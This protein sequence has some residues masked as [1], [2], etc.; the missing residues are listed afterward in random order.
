MIGRMTKVID[1]GQIDDIE[2]E[3]E[4]KSLEE[5]LTLLESSG[6]PLFLENIQFN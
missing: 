4:F 3:K 1:L 2:L 6:V 5:H